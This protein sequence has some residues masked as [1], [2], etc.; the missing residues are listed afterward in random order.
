MQIYPKQNSTDNLLS[1][2]F[3]RILFGGFFY[4]VFAGIVRK[5]LFPFGVLSDIL[6][7]GQLILPIVLSWQ[8]N[9][10]KI[11]IKNSY[12]SILILY[13]LVLLFLAVN[14]LNHT[15]FHGI[16]GIIIHLGFWY[17]LLAY[18]KIADFVEIRQLDNFLIALLII[19]TI[20]AS[21][22]YSLPPDHIINRYSAGDSTGI[23]IGD[24]IRVTGTFSY[25]GGFASMVIFYGFFTWSLLN[26]NQKPILVIVSMILCIYLALMSG[27]RGNFI[28]ICVLIAVGI[29][30]NIE[31]G[32]KYFR[33]F[34]RIGLVILIIS[35][36]FNPI[37]PIIRTWDN[38]YG[39]T[40]ELTERGESTGR[41]YKN[42]FSAFLYHGNQP[43]F[44]AG[45]GSDYQGANAIFGISDTK[46]QYGYTEEEGERI[47]FEGGYLL[48]LTRIA[49]FLIVL[50]S[51]KIKRLSKV[52]LFILFFNKLL[53]FNTYMTFF[54][55]MGFIWVNQT[56]LVKSKEYSS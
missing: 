19:E 24:G 30:E 28:T 4:T 12:G 50:S 38:F 34:F 52:I 27:G 43:L 40:S 37:Q 20:L 15:I 56:G 26:R 54:V 3:Q 45:L 25:L 36:F 48:Y 53:V 42:Y 32:N 23:S 2:R 17:L 16:I 39:R 44:G 6:L 55:A 8:Y 47:V 51:M 31:K 7:F 46:Q 35:V 5:W 29:Y 18:L 11:T 49:L 14:P 9:K 10:T 13:F 33:Y 1:V 41:I 21:I 22:Q